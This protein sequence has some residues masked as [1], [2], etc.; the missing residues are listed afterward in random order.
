MADRRRRRWDLEFRT[1]GARRSPATTAALLQWLTHLS[2]QQRL[3]LFTIENPWLTALLRHMFTCKLQQGEGGF[4]VSALPL[5]DRV[6]HYFTFCNMRSDTAS[7]RTFEQQ[8]RLCDTRSYLDTVTIALEAVQDFAQ[9]LQLANSISQGAVFQTPCLALWDSALR[10]WIWQCPPWVLGSAVSLAAV[11]LAAFEKNCWLGFFKAVGRDPRA[12]GEIQVFT[13]DVSD[14]YQEDIDGLATFW[15]SLPTDRKSLIIGSDDTLISA[16]HLAD[17]SLRKEEQE[18]PTWLITHTGRD[19][20]YYAGCRTRLQY[21]SSVRSLELVHAFVT[22]ENV[23]EYIRFLMLSPLERTGTPFD[24]VARQTLDRI[25]EALKAQIAEDLMKSEIAISTSQSQKPKNKKKRKKKRNE[26]AH[27][28]QSAVP[29]K[30]VSPP[31]PTSR[32]IASELINFILTRMAQALEDTNEFLIVQ[33]GRK[34]HEKGSKASIPISPPSTKRA[35]SEYRPCAAA[36]PT[37][38]AVS[39]LEAHPSKPCDVVAPSES[40]DLPYERLTSEAHSYKVH[41][42]KIMISRKKTV[43]NLLKC[44]Q[45]VAC[46]IFP[47]AYIGIFGSFATRLALPSSDLDLVISN[48][49]FSRPEI[50]S[51][52]TALAV[53]ISPCKWTVS[54][55]PIPTA[56]VPVVKLTVDPLCFGGEFSEELKVDITFENPEDQEKR[57]IGLAAVRW[58]KQLLQAFPFVQECVLVL[59]QVLYLKQLNS[60]YLGGLSSYSVVLWVAAYLQAYPCK[61][62]GDLIM[63]VLHFYGSEFQPSFTGISQ[64]EPHF[65]PRPEPIFTVCETLDPISPS[66]NTTKSAFRLSDVQ[67]LFRECWEQLKTSVSLGHKD[68]LARLFAH[69]SASSSIETSVH[70]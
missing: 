35:E 55:Q 32:E 27:T 1:P 11:A 42:W 60:A 9:C 2:A 58:V 67:E 45:E 59:K 19:D 48:T 17:I 40:V 18:T 3:R 20:L 69:I 4:S 22:E 24:T 47:G 54:V 63:G 46:T 29:E 65:Y 64:N 36:S 61:T 66:N 26:P 43:M 12:P 49:G 57:H 38:P 16:F 44:L 39:S 50:M 8:L 52:V 53:I 28:Q 13:W 56:T 70:C 68:P 6:D 51:A 21:Y 41:I 31:V 23:G 15:T 7:E 10:T 5:T 62:S 14:P 30:V 33:P 34:R 37:T 25:K